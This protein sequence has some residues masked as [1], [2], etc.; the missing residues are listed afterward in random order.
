MA[1]KK[2]KKDT[3]ASGEPAQ[4]ASLLQTVGAIV[5]GLVAVKLA[6]T[7]V[8]TMWRLVTRENPPQVDEQVPIA[9]K[10]LWIGLVGAATGAAR[11]AARDIVKPPRRT[12]VTC[13]GWG[14]GGPAYSSAAV[15][16]KPP[17]SLCRHPRAPDLIPPSCGVR[18]L[19]LRQLHHRRFVLGGRFCPGDLVSSAR[20]YIPSNRLRE[21]ACRRET[22]T[23]S[24]FPS[25]T[26]WRAPAK[27]GSIA[28]ARLRFMR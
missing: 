19:G 14:G 23:R 5:A 28:C 22:G 21:R 17:L 1:K 7:I 11:Q 3:T 10:A 18:G 13:E 4:K 25:M 6:T 26:T 27:S 20:R 9:K 2:V 24:A 12:R 8:T 15:V 16:S